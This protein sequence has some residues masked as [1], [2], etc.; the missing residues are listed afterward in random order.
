MAMM[1]VSELGDARI[2]TVVEYYGPT[3]DPKVLFPDLDEADLRA[4]ASWMAP[5]HYVPEM[6][7]L[8][9]TIPIRIVHAGGNII[10]VDTGVGNRKRRPLQRMNMLNNLVLPWMEAAGAPRDKVT[11]VVITHMHPDHTGWNTVLD[12]E[13]WVPTFPNAR[14]LFPRVD[15]EYFKARYDENPAKVNDYEDS[16]FP[17]MEAGL[18]ELFEAEGEIAGCLEVIPAPGHTAGQVMFR[19]RSGDERAIFAADVV[20]SPLQ[21]AVPSLNSSYDIRPDLSIRT[22]AALL[23]E[24]ADTGAL[25]LPTHFGAPFRG[26]VRREREGYRFEPVEG[27]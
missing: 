20:H 2:T 22:R 11:H 10:V 23:A 5:S 25:I 8:V 17:V 9:I 7:R 15:Y 3:H 24:A 13:R 14:Y 26:Y 19:L 6:N 18:A 27:W 21:I 1:R 16:V 4:N 12:G